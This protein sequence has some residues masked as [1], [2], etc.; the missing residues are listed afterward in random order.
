M[1]TKENELSVLERALPGVLAKC[2]QQQI[3]TGDAAFCHKSIARQLVAAKRD[4][5]LQLKVKAPHMTDVRL[6]REGFAQLT[7]SEALARSEEK[8]GAKKVPNG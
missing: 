2:P 6:A 1:G 3:L 4:Y 5:F 8:R 7:Q